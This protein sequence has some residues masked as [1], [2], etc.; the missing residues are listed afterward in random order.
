MTDAVITESTVAELIG[1]SVDTVR[2]MR[3]RGG[4]PPYRKYGTTRQSPV[5]YLRTEVIAWRDAQSRVSTSG[6][7]A[8]R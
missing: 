6:S 1:M 7:E 3:K 4:G 2:S 8:S 5:R